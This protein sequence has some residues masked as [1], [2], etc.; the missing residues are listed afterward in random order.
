[1]S[2]D[3]KSSD[4]FHLTNQMRKNV[5]VI[6]DKPMKKATGVMTMGEEEKQRAWAEHYG[7]FDHLSN[8]PQQEGPLLT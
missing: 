4:I 8:E 7:Y 3:H 2:I 6:G 1:M 5:D